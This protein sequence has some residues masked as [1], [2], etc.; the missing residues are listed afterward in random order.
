M[1]RY[2][3]QACQLLGN[4]WYVVRRIGS[5]N[6]A[7]VFEV[8][9]HEREAALKIYD[10]KFFEGAN[11]AVEERRILDQ[12]SLRHHGHPSLIDFFAAG[13]VA[14]TYFLLMEYFPWSSLDQCLER[15]RTDDVPNILSQVASAAQFLEERNFVHRDIKPANI[16]ISENCQLVKLLDLGV[17]RPIATDQE[18]DNTDQGYTLP[19][20]A[21]AQYSSPAYLVRD[22]D[23]TE[24]MWRALTFYQLGGVL[25]D[26]LMKRPLFSEEVRTGNRYRTAAAVLLKTPEIYAPDAPAWLLSLARTCLDKDDDRRL[27][28]VYW[29]RFHPDQS[30]DLEDLRNRLGLI[31]S[32]HAAGDDKNMDQQRQERIGLLLDQGSEHLV[33]IGRHVLVSQGFPQ[34]GMRRQDE[35]PSL[36]RSII[37]SFSPRFTPNAQLT[38]H[39]AVCLCLQCESNDQLDIF[40][41]SFITANAVDIPDGFEGDFLWTTSIDA[42]NLED[43]QLVQILTDEFIRRYAV[44]EDQVQTALV[45]NDFVLQFTHGCT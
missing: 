21:T 14:E 4:G 33:E 44:A 39:F 29:A 24:S 11:A 9:S 17:M 34:A 19:F 1:E 42:L 8:H 43:E 2:A 40:L 15:I 13:Q 7:T 5:G 31:P 45:A 38:L 16:L 12:M 23:P 32:K 18:R 6:S 36:R 22:G 27:A 35:S 10:P 3:D 28:R 25:H 37:F 30:E 26:M 41:A 20:V